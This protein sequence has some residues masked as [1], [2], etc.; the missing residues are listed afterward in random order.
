MDK[1]EAQAEITNDA[2]V[3]TPA[4]R[5][6]PI[7]LSTEQQPVHLRGCV[8]KYP[9]YHLLLAVI[10]NQDLRDMRSLKQSIA[11]DQHFLAGAEGVAWELP[12]HIT[13]PAKSSL[14][15]ARINLDIA[16]MAWSRELNR[17]PG[18]VSRQLNIDS[19]PKGGAEIM[20]INEFCIRDGSVSTKS[21][22][23]NLPLQ[24]LGFGHAGAIDKQAALIHALWCVAG[25][26]LPDLHAYCEQVA[27][28]L[29]D[30]GTEQGCVDLPDM[31]EV[32]SLLLQ[33]LGDPA[34]QRVLVPPR[35]EDDRLESH[36]ELGGR[37]DVHRVQL[38]GE[39]LSCSES[40]LQIAAVLQLRGGIGGEPSTS[41]HRFGQGFAAVL[42][43]LHK[44]EV[45]HNLR[46]LTAAGQD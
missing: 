4:A 34:P 24:C 13:V 25:P 3:D 19:S 23:T 32:Y 5:V 17:Q 44:V 1:P 28:V 27:V 18:L 6:P 30:Q 37:A 35:I 45:Q 40:C 20:A 14:L 26:T 22:H 16:T 10:A 33:G 38:V 46:C 36:V 21:T 11:K 9:P 31:L 41:R 8:T 12:P 43:V 7:V 39:V 2:I 42:G 29:T 15:R